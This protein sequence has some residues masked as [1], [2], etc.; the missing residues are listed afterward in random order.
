M[1]ISPLPLEGLR[2]IELKLFADS[3]GFFVERFREETFAEAGLSSRFVQ[4]NHNRSAPGVLRGL[5]YQYEEPQGKLVGI[6]HG[7]VWDVVVDLRIGSPTLGQHFGLELSGENGRL[8]WIPPGFAHGFCVLGDEPADMVYKVDAYWNPKG[9]GG[10][11]WS[12]P[13]LSI[14]WPLEKPL[15]SD[16]DEVMPDYPTYLQAPRFSYAPCL[17]SS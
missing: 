15:V 3:R 2:L 9:E 14:P 10:I 7:R 16:R 5:H 8:L 1:R 12:D 17:T 11:C 6:V 4:E 13:S